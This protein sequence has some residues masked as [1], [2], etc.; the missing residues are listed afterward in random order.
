MTLQQVVIL[1]V[2]VVLLAG[3]IILGAVLDRR[4]RPGK[5]P[6]W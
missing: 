2:I 3:A 4:G 5:P 1:A 6:E